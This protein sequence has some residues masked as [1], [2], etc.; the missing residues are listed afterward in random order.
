MSARRRR[1]VKSNFSS[2]TEAV[3][4]RNSAIGGLFISDTRYTVA[5]K[6]KLR[7][8]SRIRAPPPPNENL[9]Q[10][11]PQK[12]GTRELGEL[13]ICEPRGNNRKVDRRD[14]WNS[15]EQKLLASNPRADRSVQKF[16]KLLRSRVEKREILRLL[17]RIGNRER[18]SYPRTQKKCNRYFLLDHPFLPF[19]SSFLHFPRKRR[20]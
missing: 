20:A 12:N 3:N 10:V 15:I 4:R 9:A 16:S 18:F 6:K 11:Q 13:I 14:E 5:D 7:Y 1:R 19:H 8:K 17:E 2:F